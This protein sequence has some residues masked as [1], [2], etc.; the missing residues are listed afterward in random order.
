MLYFPH[1]NKKFQGYE[2]TEEDIEATLR[3]LQ[4]NENKDA[5][6]EDAIKYLEDKHAVAHLAATQKV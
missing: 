3:Y 1:M 4:A 6:R 2:I 5:T